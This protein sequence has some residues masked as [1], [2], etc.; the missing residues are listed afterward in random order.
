MIPILPDIEGWK[1]VPIEE[2]SEELISLSDFGCERIKVSPIY[3]SAGL[4]GSLPVAYLRKGVVKKLA[5]AAGILPDGLH[6]VVWDAW[7]PLDVQEVLY[8]RALE[9]CRQQHP[10]L[11][12]AELAELA[13]K[14]AARPSENPCAPYPH[15]TGGGLDLTLANDKGNLLEMGSKH[16]SI[17]P[18]SVTRFYEAKLE[19]EQVLSRNEQLALWNRRIL[20][21]ALN[22]AGFTNYP[23]EWW[24]FDFGDQLWAI[25]NH[26]IARYG[27]ASLENREINLKDVPL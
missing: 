13:E 16:D 14:F 3:Y 12:E 25:Q 2:C 6:F 21:H 26:A 8:E 18:V 11:G 7:R 9:K 19:H 10:H 4:R 23:G 22:L 15:S 27:K 24:H 17:S 1:N 5:E 20:F